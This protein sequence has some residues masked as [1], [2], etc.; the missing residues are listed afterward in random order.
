MILNRSK[1]QISVT[2]QFELNKTVKN[3]ELNYIAV[4]K[5]TITTGKLNFGN[6]AT[7]QFDASKFDVVINPKMM[8]DDRLIKAWGNQIY[9][10]KLVAKKKL[11]KD[12][13]QI[14]I[15]QY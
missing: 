11:L 15:K 2:D 3:N 6:K 13:Y 10:I 12:N 14:T 7:L 8:D 5:P 9:Q 1:K 4:I